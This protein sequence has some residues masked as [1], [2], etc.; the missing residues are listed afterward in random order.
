M[1][2]D[3]KWID[4]LTFMATPTSGHGVILDA[5]KDKGG[6]GRGPSPMELLLMG[7]G[8]CT[9]IDVVNILKKARQEVTG[10]EIHV[11]GVRQE[12]NPKVFTTMKVIYTF[13]GKNLAKEQA[14][15]AVQLSVEKYCCVSIMLGKT[16]AISHEIIIKEA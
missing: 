6:D 4:G 5:P 2:A 11:E 1:H 3:V 8:G 10:V 12:E 13:T 14:E 15:R 9:G 7:A 16:A